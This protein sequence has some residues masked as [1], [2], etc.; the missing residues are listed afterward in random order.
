MELIP[1]VEGLLDKY[2]SAQRSLVFQTRI[3]A[4]KSKE[5]GMQGL[6][7]LPSPGGEKKIPELNSSR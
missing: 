7:D 5:W 6:F 4:R 2:R 1:K 3:S